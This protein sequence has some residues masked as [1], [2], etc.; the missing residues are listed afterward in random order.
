MAFTMKITVN[1]IDPNDKTTLANPIVIETNGPMDGITSY[2]LMNG[3]GNIMEKISAAIL[4]EGFG[5]SKIGENETM[6]DDP[7]ETMHKSWSK[8]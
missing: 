8:H 2:F 6:D 1:D 3:I 7:I 4:R 5:V